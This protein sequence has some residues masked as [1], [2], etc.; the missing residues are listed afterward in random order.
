M[1]EK[2]DAFAHFKN[3]ALEVLP[4]ILE[5]MDE[6]RLIN[7]ADLID[8]AL[9]RG[10]RVHIT[11][12][13]KPAHIAGYIASLMSSTGTPTYFLPVSY[14]HLAVYKRQELYLKDV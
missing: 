1:A 4:M 5:Q 12:I 6:D 9:R 13:G 7:A 3:A 14:T 2:N 10:G 8:D 11:G